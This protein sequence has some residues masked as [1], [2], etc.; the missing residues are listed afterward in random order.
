MIL[1][2]SHNEDCSEQAYLVQEFP[3]FIECE[4]VLGGDVVEEEEVIVVVHDQGQ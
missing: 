3:L 1:I 4:L 2:G